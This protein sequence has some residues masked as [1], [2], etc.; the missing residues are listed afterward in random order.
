MKRV[1]CT[2]VVLCLLVMLPLGAAAE[3]PVENGLNQ[4]EAAEMFRTVEL[5]LGEMQEEPDAQAMKALLRRAKGVAFFPSVVKIGFGIG[6]L[7]GDGFLLERGE[8][9]QWMGP[10]FM[11]IR[12]L[13]YGW[14]VG[15]QSIGMMLV[16]ANERG[17][18]NFRS[19]SLNLGG[20]VSVAVGPLGRRGELVTDMRL[21]ASV[22]GYSIARGAFIGASIAG[23]DISVDS[24]KNAR[25]WGEDLTQEELFQRPADDERIQPVLERLQEMMNQAETQEE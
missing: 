10:S 2:V 1:R 9:G 13:S 23:S 25:Y 20:D 7:M 17:M 12:G 4:G 19:G 5:L 21:E 22:Y 24:D 15:L 6:A 16:I 14:Q 18:E 11:K 3:T 8:N